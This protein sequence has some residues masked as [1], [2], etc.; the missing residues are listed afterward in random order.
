MQGGGHIQHAVADARGTEAAALQFELLNDLAVF[1]AGLHNHQL[2][3]H[4]RAVEQAVHIERGG[5]Q[6]GV[7]ELLLP[8]LRAGVGID[9]IQRGAVIKLIHHI[10]HQNGGTAG[11]GK[12][13]APDF[14]AWLK[15]EAF[16]TGG[17]TQRLRQLDADHAALFRVVEVLIPMDGDQRALMQ[18][19]GGVHA[20]F[21]DGH[22]PV[23]VTIARVHAD[24]VATAGGVI[25]HT[26]A[27]TRF[28]HRSG[29]RAVHR[30]H[31]AG[32]RP[33]DQFAGLFVKG[34]HA[35]GGRT[36]GTPVGVDEMRHHQIALDHR[37]AH[38]G[39]GEG[40][41]AKILHQRNL[42]HLRAIQLPAVEEAGVAHQIDAL[43]FR[44]D[45]RRA[46]GV[47]VV[48]R[49]AQVVWNLMLPQLLAR[50]R[51]H[52][53]DE[54][55]EIGGFSPVAP[56]DHFALKHHRRATAADVHGPSWFFVQLS[57][58]GVMLQAHTVLQRAAPVGPVIRLRDTGEGQSGGK[59]TAEG[60]AGTVVHGLGKEVETKHRE[61]ALRFNAIF[62]P[63][64]RDTGGL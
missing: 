29:K 25:H 5:M 53:G 47:A 48:D 60:G 9:R 12:W 56:Q 63:F 3:F 55:G 42:K 18:H 41:A 35:V 13:Q 16:R 24:D 20:V 61:H 10:S 37:T 64:A 28:D 33:P 6:V 34:I 17:I 46:D 15:H 40:H 21:A 32:A 11:G 8:H 57:S 30:R 54:F 31:H 23:G 7:A 39:V 43:R 44:I 26:A 19:H 22:F 27:I 62:I 49:I 50:L 52:A 51:V 38:A 45:R 2:A 4:H 14:D 1:F 58:L 59:Q 36:I